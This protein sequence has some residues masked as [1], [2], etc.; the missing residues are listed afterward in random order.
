MN[1]GVVLSAG[2]GTRFG[3][4]VPKQYHYLAGKEVISFAISSLK[5][6]KLVDEILIV[7]AEEYCSE[8]CERYDVVTICGGDT[9]NKSLW[10][11]LQYVK[12]NYCCENIIILE[13]ARPM[14]T[15]CIVDQ[16]ISLLDQYDGVITCKKISDSLGAYDK[17]VILR[18]DFY[19]IQAPEAFRFNLL[20][21]NFSP[22]S[23]IT[24]TSQQLPP[25]SKIYLNFDF[26]TNHKIT[27]P[28]D[29]VYCECM[30][31]YE[32]I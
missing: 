25:L 31:R 11:A 29:L 8:L 9:R 20:Y 14:V 4:N 13:A 10:A 28:E 19:L 22:E 6:S 5:N 7:A 23:E 15:E 27:Y 2:S 12:N 30:M 32:Q 21:D 1:V 24:A 17:N 16:Y 26:M 3:A 18:D